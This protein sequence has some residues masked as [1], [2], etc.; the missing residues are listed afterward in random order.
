MHARTFGAGPALV[1]GYHGWAGSH[2]D[3]AAIGR[4]LPDTHRLVAPDLPGHGMSPPLDR[5]DETTLVEALTVHLDGLESESVTLVGYCS[6]A[7]LALLVADRRPHRVR[8]IVAVDPFAYLPWYF[9]IF[10]FGEFGRRAYRTTFANPLG[11][12]ITEWS[13]QRR[14]SPDAGFMESFR[15]ANHDVVLAYLRLFASLGTL[16][17]F[18]GIRAPIVLCRGART[19]AAVKRSVEMFRVVWPDASEHVIQDAGHLIMIHGARRI[20]ALITQP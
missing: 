12:M 6:G 4:G 16:D 2:R 9:R 7:I 13:L 10:T 8:R 3:F 19:F 11:R 18:A 20:R 17:R 14:K 15:G 1:V 5:L